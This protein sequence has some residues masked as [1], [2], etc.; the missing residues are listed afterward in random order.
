MA[1][2]DPDALYAE[3]VW[4]SGTRETYRIGAS[5]K[6]ELTVG[7]V[8]LPANG[9][10]NGFL[11]S[12]DVSKYAAGQTFNCPGHPAHGMIVA[13][14]VANLGGILLV[15]PSNYLVPQ[16]YR[17]VPRM[18][19]PSDGPPA[20][21]AVQPLDPKPP[22]S[23]WVAA[24]AAGGGSNVEGLMEVPVG[25]DERRSVVE[26]FH[27]SRNDVPRTKFA[28][29]SVKRVQSVRLWEQYARRREDVS[30][31][32]WSCPNERT[33]FHGTSRTSP[34]TIVRDAVGFD[35][36]FS[37]PGLYGRGS[38]FAVDAAYSDK[39][40]HERPDGTYQ[41]FLARVTLGRVQEPLGKDLG[42]TRRPGPGCHSIRGK[43]QLR[44]GTESEIFV[45][46]ETTTQAYPEYLITYAD[47]ASAYGRNRGTRRVI[48]ATR[49]QGMMGR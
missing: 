12:G 25:S 49:P 9:M 37:A 30:A 32:N 34:E 10:T 11:T 20:L 4:P 23:S 2:L 29:L 46:Y 42:S 44:G 3:V 47:N 17:S 40:R 31:E 28:V 1:E 43:S 7:P 27:S 45:V 33:L 5:L 35:P 26:R 38:Y 22:P 14:A 24:A 36:R 21:G 13:A 41:M 18:V 48:K 16:D 15:P 19:R 39:Y 6:M 8:P